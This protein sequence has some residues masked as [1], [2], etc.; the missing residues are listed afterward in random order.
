MLRIFWIII[1][2]A[3][4]LE[5]FACL[6][7]EGSFAID[8]ETM[9]LDQKTEIGREYSLPFNDFILSFTF[10]PDP[11]SSKAFNFRYK[12][13]ER[14]SKKLEMVSLGEEDIKVGEKREIYA[15]GLEKKPHS[16][17]DLKLSEI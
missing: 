6:R 3:F 13:E 15:K 16:I 14:T 10:H 2:L 11:K 12:V 8:G 9:K 7:V 1:C 5:A 17:I 4:T